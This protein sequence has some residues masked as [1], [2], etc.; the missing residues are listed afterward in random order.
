MPKTTTRREFILKSIGYSLASLIP[1]SLMARMPEFVRSKFNADSTAE[2]VTAGLDLSDKTVLVTGA[3]SGLGYETMRVLALRG[4]HVLAAARNM[5][6][7]AKAAASVIGNVTPIVCE[8]TDFESVVN[9][10]KSV[11]KHSLGKPLDVLICN[12]GIMGGS[13]LQTVNGLEKQFVVN[14]L[15]HFL[16]AQRLLPRLK[17]APQGRLV[18]VSS[19]L[20]TKAPDTGIEFDNLSGKKSYDRFTAYGQSKLAMALFAAEFSQRFSG[21]SVTANALYP[22]VIQTNLFRNMPWYVKL[23][24]TV[25]G[26]AFLK[27]VEEGAA[28]QCYVASHP[29][30]A[31]VSGHF[32]AD[33][34]PIVLEGPHMSDREL[35]KNL[36]RVSLELTESYLN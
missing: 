30:L 22:G 34:N 21:E 14:Y 26:W 13:D 19:G 16:L 15:G 6:K 27:S 8:L 25:G 1:H 24:F 11:E 23:G 2:E 3:N 35:A 28:T 36:W 12:A 9:C 31:N 5:E 7:A 33:C 17:A 4:A 10:A 32:F 20:Y 29:S 18:M